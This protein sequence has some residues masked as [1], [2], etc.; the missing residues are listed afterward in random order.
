MK[1]FPLIPWNKVLIHGVDNARFTAS[2]ILLENI[3]LAWIPLTIVGSVKVPD[4]N[5]AEVEGISPFAERE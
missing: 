4:L 2:N 1:S 3:A 5:V